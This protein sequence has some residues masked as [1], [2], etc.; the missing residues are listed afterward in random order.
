MC[1]KQDNVQANSEY[2]QCCLYLSSLFKYL[3]C[4]FDDLEL[5]QFKVIRGQRSWCQSMTSY[6]T[7]IDANIVS[8]T[9]FEIFDV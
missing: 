2:A 9:F 7:S 5:G 6:S 1:L 8:V 4:N 3:T